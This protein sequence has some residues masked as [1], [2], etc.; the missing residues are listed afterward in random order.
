MRKS[1][2][3][4]AIACSFPSCN[5]N[6]MT[7]NQNENRGYF[8]TMEGVGYKHDKFS[9]NYWEEAENESLNF[10]W[11]DSEEEMVTLVFDDN[12]PL[13]F[14]DG[15]K[16]SY[17]NVSRNNENRNICRMEL[18][19]GLKTKFTDG[20]V[21]WGV[22]P[23]N[24]QNIFETGEIVFSMPEYFEYFPN[25][26][27][28]T[29]HLSDFLFMSGTGIVENNKVQVGFNILPAIFRFRITNSD[30]KIMELHNISLTGP[31]NDVA[32]L[33]YDNSSKSYDTLFFSE[34]DSH[35]IGVKCSDYISIN[36]GESKML[37]ALVFPTEIS[38]ENITIKIESSFGIMEATTSYNNVFKNQGLESNTYYTLG[39]PV[40]RKRVEFGY[41]EISD[42]LNGDS[43]I[44]DLVEKE[45]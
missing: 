14:V 5:K 35:S 32:T 1:V 28:P 4:V 42:F 16:Y 41:T 29:E 15:N 6:I 23:V 18:R 19:T 21:V 38:E 45:L 8:I 30:T 7:E 40:S 12:F 2:L 27:V 26:E 20:N 39:I 3:L 10:F 9:R 17:V 11:E 36:P 25:Q 43:F 33:K 31:F 44:V 13:E 24:S 22:C 37:Y 34:K